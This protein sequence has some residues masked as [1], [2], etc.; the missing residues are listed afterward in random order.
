MRGLQFER[1]MTLVSLSCFP[2]VTS[3][4]GYF[5]SCYFF[6]KIGCLHD[7]KAAK[8]VLIIYKSDQFYVKNLQYEVLWQDFNLI[9]VEKPLT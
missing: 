1:K 3:I 8:T 4:E 7:V 9:T 2:P 5:A 6:A